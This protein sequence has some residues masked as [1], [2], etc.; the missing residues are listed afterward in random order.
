MVDLIQQMN[1]LKNLSD[2]QLAAEM[3][4][5]TGGAA[6]FMVASEINRRKDMRDRYMAQAA[7][8]RPQT[9][10]AA[11]LLGSLGGSSMSPPAG[12]PG[13]QAPASAGM[14]G[15]PAQGTPAFASGGIVDAL[16]YNTISKDYMDDLNES[17]KMRDRAAAMALIAAGAGMMGGG[18]SNT[19]S[20]VGV[21]LTAGLDAYQSGLKTADSA[22][23]SALDG[24]MRLSTAQHGDALTRLQMEQQDRLAK[25]QIDAPTAHMKDYTFRKGLSPEEQAAWDAQNPPYNPNAMTNDLRIADMANKIY[26]DAQKKYPINEYDPEGA[27]EQLRKARIEAYQRIKALDAE[28]AD[29]WA[30]SM[31]LSDGDLVITDA[32]GISGEGGDILK[33]GL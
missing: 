26:E 10:V 14:S 18:H 22:R 19:L 27:P 17:A 15:L 33:L 4:A 21:G 32:G 20:N 30:K 7:S 9:T 28:Y 1:L 16:D 25:E 11:D 2:D 13:M 5:P 23:S 31:G 3:K 24:L 12:A 6:P 29:K 8:Q